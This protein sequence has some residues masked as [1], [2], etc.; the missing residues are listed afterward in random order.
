MKRAAVFGPA[1]YSGHS[2]KCLYT[3]QAIQ[4]LEILIGHLCLQSGI[5]VSL[6]SKRHHS[7][8]LATLSMHQ[9]TAGTRH[10]ILEHPGVPLTRHLDLG[11]ITSIRTFLAHI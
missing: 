5:T 10:L 1:T 3:E 9:L 8:I 11:W 2:I 7:V 4:Q 6:P